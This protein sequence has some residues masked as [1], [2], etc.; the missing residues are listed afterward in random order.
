MSNPPLSA[1]CNLEK[2]G[3]LEDGSRLGGGVEWCGGR[4]EVVE[5]PVCGCGAFLGHRDR[6]VGLGRGP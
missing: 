1:A 3:L 2:A 4:I 5:K 6:A